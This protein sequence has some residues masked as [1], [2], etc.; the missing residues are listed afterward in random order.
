MNINL[1]IFIYYLFS[2][3]YKNIDININ[4]FIL[5]KINNN[6]NNNNSKLIIP[7]DIYMIL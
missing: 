5:L 3:Y 6:N 1:I 4:W 7:N 2:E